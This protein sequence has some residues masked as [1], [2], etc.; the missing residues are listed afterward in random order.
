VNKL[1]KM[2]FMFML[3]ALFIAG[4]AQATTYTVQSNDSQGT[5]ADMMDLEH[6]Y[7]YGWGISDTTAKQL[8]NELLKGYV[9]TSATLVYKNIWNWQHETNDQL[10]TFLLSDAPKAPGVETLPVTINGEP[11]G[12]NLYTYTRTTYTYT[13]TTYTFQE[14]VY[15]YSYN[16]T[17]TSKQP[18][19]VTAGYSE[20]ANKNK[21]GVIVSYTYKKTETGTSSTAP[22]GFIVASSKIL[23]ITQIDDSTVPAGYTLTHTATATKTSLNVPLAVPGD[24]VLTGTKTATKTSTSS[25]V[26]SGYILTGTN[27]VQD[28]VTLKA[29]VT[30]SSNLWERYDG[31]S[32][33][34]VN[35]E[36]A[37]STLIW[38]DPAKGLSANANPWHD[39]VGGHS[40][41]LDLTYNF[42]DNLIALLT[43][44]ALDGTYG[45]GV[46]PDC[47]YYNEGV[48]FTITTESVPEPATM[49]L[50]GLGLMGLAGVRRKFKK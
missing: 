25:A 43:A 40:R 4:G 45:F 2:V 35:W 17:F 1:S 16:H 18:A 13:K 33:A 8:E 7:Y 41:N 31:Q 48:S 47:H 36:V 44:Y 28:M 23:T 5:K 22:S 50:L 24:Y 38:D 20:T 19:L 27:F 14:K 10:T 3:L 39:V 6:D 49:L 37:D 11:Q 30:L 12:H 42:D 32:K 29:G 15:T 34:D 9:I 21:Y 26:P 46:D